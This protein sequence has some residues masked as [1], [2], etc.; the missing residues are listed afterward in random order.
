MA[1]APSFV[2]D[3][4]VGATALNV[5]VKGAGLFPLSVLLFNR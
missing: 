4:F 2:R 3:E 1:G 5:F